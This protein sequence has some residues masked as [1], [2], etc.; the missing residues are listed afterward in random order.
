MVAYNVVVDDAARYQQPCV[1][2]AVALASVTI[3]QSSVPLSQSATPF[4]VLLRRQDQ[5]IAT[6]LHAS[7]PSDSPL[8][9]WKDLTNQ[10]NSACLGLICEAEAGS[11]A[12]S[13]ILDDGLTGGAVPGV[14]AVMGYASSYQ[15]IFDRL[16]HRL[17]GATTWTGTATVLRHVALNIP[18][19]W[20]PIAFFVSPQD[21]L[22]LDCARA[23]HALTANGMPVKLEIITSNRDDEGVTLELAERD[24][25]LR[26]HLVNYFPKMF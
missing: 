26:E 18:F 15:E 4:T 9:R 21:P 13:D 22:L 8:Q 3:G 1:P 2:N 19:E 23:C 25:F 5:L 6:E 12:I 24:R 20:P 16:L 17:R 11:S 7:M 14:I 10:T